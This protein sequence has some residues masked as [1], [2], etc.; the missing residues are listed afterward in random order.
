[1]SNICG[2]C[3]EEITNFQKDCCTTNCGHSFHTSCLFQSRGGKCPNCRTC[4]VPQDKIVG[5][6]KHSRMEVQ[7]LESGRRIQRI[8]RIQRTQ[9][10][11]NVPDDGQ[12]HRIM[13]Q[14]G[15]RFIRHFNDNDNDNEGNYIETQSEIRKR[16]SEE[17]RTR[18]RMINDRNLCELFTRKNGQIIR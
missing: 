9:Q 3:L 17:R 2:I 13:T 5:S 16:E 10:N 7:E 1:M 15:V 14:H 4:I 11:Y 6:A 12:W 8:Q 18:Q